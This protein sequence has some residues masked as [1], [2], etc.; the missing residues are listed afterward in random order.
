MRAYILDQSPLHPHSCDDNEELKNLLSLD[1]I[2]VCAQLLIVVK[3]NA[4]YRALVSRQGQE[5]Q[6]LLNL[7]QAVST[8]SPRSLS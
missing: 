3:D 6:S 1:I 8:S 4:E 5:A 7:L 2:A